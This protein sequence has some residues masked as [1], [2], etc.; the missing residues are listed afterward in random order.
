MDSPKADITV[1]ASVGAPVG[2]QTKTLGL[3]S[4]VFP[5]STNAFT[6]FL[7]DANGYSTVRFPLGAHA[8]S[9]FMEWRCPI[10]SL[11]PLIPPHFNASM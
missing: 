8:F 11:L 3:K 7:I 6:A 9:T 4:A 1:V 10:P 5:G 2:E